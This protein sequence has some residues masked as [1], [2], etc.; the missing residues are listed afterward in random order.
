MLYRQIPDPLAL[1]D[2]GGSDDTFDQ[3]RGDADGEQRDNGKTGEPAQTVGQGNTHTPDEAA[4]EQEGDHGLT[5]GAEGEVG[6]VFAGLAEPETANFSNSTTANSLYKSDGSGDI[7]G[8]NGATLSDIGTTNNPGYRMPRYRNDNTNTDSTINSNTNVANMTGT[9]QNIYGYG[10]YY[11]W[12]AAIANTTA[13][14]SNNTSATTTSLCPSGWR[15]PQGGNKTRIESNDDNDFWN[16]V[17]DELNNGTQPANYSSQ[18]RPYYTGSDEAGPVDK[19]VRSF[20][21]NFVYSGYVSGSSVSSRGSY[22]YYWSSTA[23]NNNNVYYF[24]FDSTY[25]NP[26]TN[27]NYKYNGRA[28]RCIVSPSV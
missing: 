24:Y 26:G 16:L 12:H 22:G 13:I 7:A 19:L 27:Y 3:I 14:T 20:P 25:V 6:G 11:S 21:N 4:V 8:I 9:T 15:L 17:V 1:F 10:N 2:H 18:D 28:I 23:Y 5:A